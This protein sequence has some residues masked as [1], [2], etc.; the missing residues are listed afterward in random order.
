MK[1]TSSIEDKEGHFRNDHVFMKARVSP[2]GDE[3][4][5][6]KRFEAT[7]FVIAHEHLYCS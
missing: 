3:N 5:K 1:D 2:D 4:V 7:C 6:E